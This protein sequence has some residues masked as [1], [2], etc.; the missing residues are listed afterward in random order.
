MQPSV[1]RKLAAIMFTDIVGYT[2][3]MGE[4]EEKGR[5]VRKRHAR[6][7]RPLVDRYRGEW[8]QDVGDETL[9]WFQ[10][11]VDA[12]NCALAIQAALK[13]DPLLSIRIGIHLG[14][15]VFE[16][17]SIHG[18]GVNVA[19]RVRPLAEPGGICVSGEVH[20]SIKNQ[21]NIVTRSLGEQALKNVD[22][23]V[24]VFAISGTAAASTPSARERPESGRRAPWAIAALVVIAIGVG[25][26]LDRAAPSR[27]SIASIAVLPLENLS[28][29][30]EQEYFSDGMT[31]ALIDNLAKLRSLSVTSRTSV[32]QYKGARLPLPE[33]A[34]SLGVDAVVEGTVLRVAGVVRITAQLIDARH[35]RHLWSASY[36]R[37]LRDV[38]AI[39]ADVARDI[40][41]QI[42]RELAPAGASSASAPPVDPQAYEEFLKGMHFFAWTTPEGYKKAKLHLERAIEIAPDFAPAYAVLAAAYS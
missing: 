33:I 17:G 13:D 29:D 31:E 28:G 11:A 20:R 37:Q 25:W 18:D 26:W 9:T 8:V 7:L 6:R 15:V 27:S 24:E 3:L 4:S 21:T 12:V 38:L 40:A 36:E 1:E 39:Q 2:A 41:R 34:R 35:D 5:E 30:P 10:S 22:R 14:D 42:G 19:A 23:P 32:M 16:A